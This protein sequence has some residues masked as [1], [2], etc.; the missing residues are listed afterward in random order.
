MSSNV[1]PLVQFPKPPAALRELRCWLIWRSE[2]NPKRPDKNRKVPYYASG[3][4]RVGVQAGQSDRAQLV[5]FKEALTAATRHKADGVGL[6]ILPDLGVV[7]VDFDNCVTEGQVRAEVLALLDGTYAEISPSGSGVRAFFRGSLESRKSFAHSGHPFDVEFFGSSGFVTYTG[8]VLDECALLGDEDTVAELTPVV[9]ELYRQRFNT[10][11]AASSAPV[12]RDELMSYEPKVGVSVDEMRKA[13]AKLDPDMPEPEWAKVLWA[14]HHETAGSEEGRALAH[15]WSSG[16][17]AVDKIAAKYEPEAVDS[18]W[19]RA[20]NQ[21]RSPVTMR[22]VLKQAAALTAKAESVETKRVRF[23]PQQA[24]EFMLRK[25]PSWIVKGLLPKADLAM[26]YGESGSGKSFFILDLCVAIARGVPW[27]GKRVKQH[28]VVYIAAEGAGGV[29]NRVQAFCEFHGIDSASLDLYLIGEQP[30]LL[31]IDDVGPLTEELKALGEVGVVV[32]DTLAQTTPGANENAGEDMGKA[33]GHCRHI[34]QVT[35][36]LVLLVHHAGKDASKGARGWSGI[37]AACD[38]EIEI[39]RNGEARCAS[40]TKLKDGDD[41]GDFGFRLHKVVIGQD[42]DGDE[43]TSCVLQEAEVS[44]KPPVQGKAQAAI[45]S[46][47]SAFLGVAGDGMARAALISDAMLELPEPESGDKDRR[48]ET[49]RRA[50][51]AM[52]ES[53]VLVEK[54]EFVYASEGA[55]P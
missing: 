34:G 22:S 46:V 54:D 42:E 53:G 5:S 25:P 12:D 45:W 31:T 30:N 33:L 24:A 15:E 23:K 2:V 11:Q 49:I 4:R 44:K 7:A 26:V 28:R 32:V 36:A 51:S 18:R 21:G 1:L 27:R 8:R 37:R 20:G 47:L 39:T 3:N 10:V 50:L 16:G 6:A 55:N 14:I 13:L 52:L 17:L 9:L 43:I 19:E 29:R 40:I 48:R 38:A 41:T 35:G